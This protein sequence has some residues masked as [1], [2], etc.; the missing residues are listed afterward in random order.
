MLKL[1]TGDKWSGG[2]GR[3]F[4]R[5][6]RGVLTRRFGGEIGVSK[7]RS[8][9]SDADFLLLRIAQRKAH[10]EWKYHYIVNLKVP[11]MKDVTLPN[12]SRTFK[13]KR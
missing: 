2:F 6:S 11:T 9:D 10:A 1:G 8:E 3:S 12:K 5:G 4:E 13:I 7:R